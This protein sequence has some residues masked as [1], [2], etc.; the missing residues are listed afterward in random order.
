MH[1]LSTVCRVIEEA[2]R[3]SRI[4]ALPS[5]SLEYITIPYSR[6]WAFFSTPGWRRNLL[7]TSLFHWTLL[8]EYSPRIFHLFAKA[9]TPLV[10]FFRILPEAVNPLS[11]TPLSIQLTEGFIFLT[12]ESLLMADSHLPNK[13]LPSSQLNEAGD[14]AKVICWQGNF[15]LW[16][17][18][19]EFES[20]SS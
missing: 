10:D 17:K 16:L 12:P 9:S 18:R 2:L 6:D 15:N 19:I 1:G 3:R 13:P 20:R 11:E 7:S 14:N 8:C 4:W 5:K